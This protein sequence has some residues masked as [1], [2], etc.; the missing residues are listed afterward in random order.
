MKDSL[1]GEIKNLEQAIRE[2]K[3]EARLI[4]DL[5]GK[6]EAQ[7]K[8]K[9]LERSRN[10]KRK[11][12]FTA[13]DKVEDDKDKLIATVEARLKQQVATETVFTVR[14]QMQ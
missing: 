12:L 7:K 4:A 13:Q 8:I 5:M 10:E 1:E 14:W 9:D 3:K 6:V 11:S 2:A